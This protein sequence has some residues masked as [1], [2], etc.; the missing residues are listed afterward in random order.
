MLGELTAANPAVVPGLLIAGPEKNERCRAATG[1]MQT[2]LST[3]K[4]QPKKL[5][6]VEEAQA[7]G[8]RND[9]DGK[10]HDELQH[11]S[12][13]ESQAQHGQGGRGKALAEFCKAC[14]L[15]GALAENL[16]A[17]YGVQ[18]FGEGCGKVREFLPFPFACAF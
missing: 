7:D 10:R 3:W 12:R 8:D 9:S 14:V 5:T 6:P 15:C 13:D 1:K 17:C 11:E 18:Q 4:K 2:T 16:Q